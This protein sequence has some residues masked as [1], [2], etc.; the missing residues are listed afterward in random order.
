MRF[1]TCSIL[2]LMLLG[3]A[4]AHA[5]ADKPTERLEEV[6]VTAT[7]RAQ[8]L[9][10]APLSATVLTADTLHAVGQQ[11]FQ[12]VLSLTPNLNWA[13]GTSRPRYFQIRGIG[14]REQYQGAPNPSV[15]FLID[16]I[17]FSGLGMAA[18]LFDV[19][20]IE[21]L[22]GPQGTRYGAN[23]LAGLIAVRT[24][25]PADAFTM[26]ATGSV[27]DYDTRSLGVM[28]S[29]PVESLSSAWRV[30]VQQYRSDG[31]RDDDFLGRDD[32]NDRDELTARAKWRWQPSAGTRVDTTFLHANLD[33]GYDAWSNDNS[34]HSEA[35]KPGKDSQRVNGGSMKLVSSDWAPA[36]VTA[37]ATLAD[38]DNVN[39]FDGDWG[40]AQYWAPNIYDFYYRADRDIENRSLELRLSS[41]D[42]GSVDTLGWLVGVY[43]FRTRERLDEL[44]VGAFDIGIPEFA[45][46]V[47]DRLQSRYRATNVALFGQLDGAWTEQW[48]WQLGVRGEQRD[49]HYR[50]SALDH[51]ADNGAIR[52]SERDRMWGGNGTISY[53]YTPELM[54]YGS[55]SRGYKAGGFNLGLAYDVQPR[56]QPEKLWSYE[57]GAKGSA[58]DGKVVFDSAAF[59]MERRDVQIRT[60][61]QSDVND[62][63]SYIFITDN[64]AKGH[65]YGLESSVHWQVA[66]EL[67]L[68]ASLG[69][70]H[71]E[72][73]GF[74]D[75]GGNAFPAR[76][77]A[78]A[79]EYQAAISATYRHPTGW[80]ARVDWSALDS[81][82]FDYDHNQRSQAYTL[83]H[84]KAGYEAR[85][86]SVYGWV[87]N[88]FDK[89]YAVRGFYFVNDPLGDTPTLFTQR[90]DPRVI[91][92]TAEW[93]FGE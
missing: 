36:T 24:A 93:R 68:A 33:N 48:S 31:F 41:P 78:H 89:N 18:T 46:T 15:G 69:L 27:A 40:N 82:Y 72:V 53:H 30:A 49:A 60:G 4:H 13:A 9:Q 2:S 85:S 90:G 42:P 56:F 66:P 16:D 61:S 28:A 76:A 22:R 88:A 63:N 73:S 55:V 39:S 77:Q 47:D 67:E 79:P 20:Q 43:G 84:L 29:A 8:P 23:A 64:A 58:F 45:F 71:T 32:T 17:D 37:I 91:G 50:D 52:D 54:L 26:S 6:I 59:Y 21:V 19:Q 1:S 81:F 62:P 35:D 87:R 10:S 38:F 57:L 74:L 75:D 7:L 65:N 51:G 70:L 14:E 25:D 80:M 44:S 12:D 86:W 5:A 11:H 34:W 83:T 92:M 3:T